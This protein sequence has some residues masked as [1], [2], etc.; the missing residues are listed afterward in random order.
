MK[1][2]FM[3]KTAKIMTEI[4]AITFIDKIDARFIEAIL[5]DALNEY[6]DDGYDEGHSDGYGEGY[7]EGRSE[8]EHD[9]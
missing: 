8:A 3:V 4:R 6:Y 2:D 7:D 1:S 5:Q 9:E